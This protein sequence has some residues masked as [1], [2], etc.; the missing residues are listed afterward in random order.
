MNKGDGFQ[1]IPLLFEAPSPDNTDNWAEIYAMVWDSIAMIPRRTLA[2]VILAMA[3]LSALLVLVFRLIDNRAQAFS[4]ASVLISGIALTGVVVSLTFQAQQTKAAR[5][6]RDRSTHRQMIY[7]TMGDRALAEC[8]EPPNT[9][10]P[11]ERYRQIIFANLIMGRWYAAYQLGDVDDSMLRYT[12]ERHFRGE[13]GRAHWEY[14][15]H[16]WLRGAIGGRRRRAAAFADLVEESYQA[17]VNAG[18]AVPAA[19]YFTDAG[20]DLGPPELTTDDSRSE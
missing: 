1:A 13:I 10:M 17:A 16:D 7:L 5:D 6:E 14:G 18:P 19:D 4:A 15:G 8:L 3:L 9:P 11:F 20:T 2:F 12:L